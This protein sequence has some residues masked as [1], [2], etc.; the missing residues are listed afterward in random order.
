MASS[1]ND[2]YASH[3]GP[4]YA[5]MIGDVDAAFSRSD[6][7]LDALSLP[8]N[9]SRTAVDLGAGFGLHA[10]PLARRG[11]SVVAIDGCEALLRD[12]QARAGSLPIRIVNGDLLGFRTHIDTAADV[13]VCMGDTLT[14]LPDQASVAALLRVVAASL[15]RGGLFAATF[16]D[17]SAALQGDARFIP[18]HADEHRVMTCFLEYGDSTVTVHDLLHE[19]EDKTWRLRVSSYRKLRLSPTWVAAQLSSLGLAVSS[20]VMPSGMIR[21][22][23]RKAST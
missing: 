9:G 11:F 15:S 19:R 7:E 21:I 18:V 23:A 20:D 16:R 2:H 22:G 12:L 5:W 4:V 13:I 17:Y 10:I 3:L 1:V 6:A 14:H 8:S